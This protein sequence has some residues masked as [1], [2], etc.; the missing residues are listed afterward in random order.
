MKSKHILLCGERGV[1]KSTLIQKLLKANTRS[2]Y[3][4]LTKRL[5]PDETGMHP[6][7]LYPAAAKTLENTQSNRIG[8]GDSKVYSLSNEV[9]NT[10]GAQYIRQARPGGIIVMDELGFME[11]KVET[12]VKTVFE[13]LDGE[14]PVIAAVKAR[15]DVLF[16][17]EVRAHPNGHVYNI[18]AEN[19]DALYEALLPTIRLWNER[20]D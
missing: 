1:G 10:L 8:A 17:N 4:F 7:Y 5:A 2:V 3:G 16:L 19:R 12:F 6:V 15:Y 13:A 14:I 9:F 18:D 20:K 11:A